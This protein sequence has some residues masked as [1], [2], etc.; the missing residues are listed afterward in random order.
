VRN[1]RIKYKL[2]IHHPCAEGLSVP[3]LIGDLTGFMSGNVRNVS[4]AQQWNGCLRGLSVPHFSQRM[5]HREAYPVH[6]LRYTQYTPWGTPAS[7]PWCIPAFLPWCIPAS[8]PWWVIASLRTMVGYSFPEDHGG[9][10]LPVHPGVYTPPVTPWVY[11][12]PRVHLPYPPL[13][14]VSALHWPWCSGEALGSGPRL[15]TERGP[16][17]ASIP[18][19]VWS[20]EEASAQC[21]SALRVDKVRKI[22]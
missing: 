9:I 18:P 10:C 4:I 22:G 11:T 15:I 20:R 21:Y 17:E 5:V 14:W 6:T 12:P 13:H 19:K 2:G 16:R 7:L 3:G 8:L 1:L